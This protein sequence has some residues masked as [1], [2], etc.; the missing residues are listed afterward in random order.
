[1][2]AL[3]VKLF[4]FTLLLFTPVFLN[5]QEASQKEQLRI[6]VWADLDP[7]PGFFDEEEHEEDST[8]QKAK[9]IVEA[10]QKD[11]K[12]SG[13]AYRFINSAKSSDI[14][15]Y[16]YAIS[17]TKEV[18]P[19]LLS[20]MISG[21]DFEY[22]PSDK[23]RRVKEYYEFT[24]I[25]EFDPAVNTI[26]YHDPEVQESKLVCWAYCDRTPMQQKE[27]ER[28]ESIVHPKIH[29]VGKGPVEKGFEGIKEACA[30]AVKNAVHVWGQSQVRSKPKEI[31][32]TVLLFKS[33]RIYIKDGWYVADLDFFLETHRIVPYTQ[34]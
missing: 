6:Q 26:T 18:A 32:G 19:F 13:T 14:S 20:G 4:F 33:P 7:F 27:F 17:R 8:L 9:E 28:W 1:M 29:G 34:F 25:R 2:E 11:N 15:P 21:W 10:E 16:A 23:L 31:S 22:T 12:Q 5:A 24:P 30:Q 3:K